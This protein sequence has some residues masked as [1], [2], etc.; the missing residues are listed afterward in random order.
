MNHFD[1][2]TDSYRAYLQLLLLQTDDQKLTQLLHKNS[3]VG[4]TN[5]HMRPLSKWPIVSWHFLLELNSNKRTGTLK[6][7]VELILVCRLQRCRQLACDEIGRRV[8][9]NR[10]QKVLQDSG[11]GHETG[12]LGSL[13]FFPEKNEFL[14]LREQKPCPEK[15]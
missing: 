6:V 8:K 7:L 2:G 1:Y 10:S 13:V 12:N 3:F 15:I 9:S 14:N 11:V 4:L 5:S